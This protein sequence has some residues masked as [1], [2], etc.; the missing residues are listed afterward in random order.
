[1]TP[2]SKFVLLIYINNVIIKNESFRSW[3]RHSSCINKVAQIVD[4]PWC[5]QLCDF[6]NDFDNIKGLLVDCICDGKRNKPKLKLEDG[7]L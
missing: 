3:L 7:E 4:F 1:M 6:T 2:K 5:F